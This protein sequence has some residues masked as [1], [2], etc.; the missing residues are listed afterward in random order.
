MNDKLYI[1]ITVPCTIYGVPHRARQQYDYVRYEYKTVDH[2]PGIETLMYYIGLDCDGEE[3]SIPSEYSVV[4]DKCIPA[5]DVNIYMYLRR[6]DMDKTVDYYKT[7]KQNLDIDM[8]LNHRAQ[9]NPKYYE[10]LS[11]KIPVVENNVE[12]NLRQN[13]TDGLQE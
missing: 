12:E 6:R 11:L 13:S 9:I 3:V 1:Q 10:A 4:V 8:R 2:R 5:A 7:V